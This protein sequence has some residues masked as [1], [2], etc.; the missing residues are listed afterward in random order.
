MGGS[1]FANGT[2]EL[3]LLPFPPALPHHTQ[4]AATPARTNLNGGASSTSHLPSQT[5]SFTKLAL[6]GRC[7]RLLKSKIMK[8][9]PAEHPN[10]RFLYS[11]VGLEFVRSWKTLRVFFRISRGFHLEILWRFV[12]TL[13]RVAEDSSKTLWRFLWWVGFFW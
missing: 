8:M 1:M 4:Q 9:T 12:E 7:L 5:A 11:G 2:R 10:S 3:A 6:L 13:E